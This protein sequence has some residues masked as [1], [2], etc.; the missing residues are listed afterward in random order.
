MKRFIVVLMVLLCVSSVYAYRKH[1]LIENFTATWCGYCPYVAQAITELEVQYGDSLNVVKY[2]PSSTDPFYRACSVTRSSYY[3]VPGYPTSIIAGNKAVVGGWNGVI[4]P[5]NNYVIQSF[6]E[7]TP[8]SIKVAITDFDRN[9]LTA[10]AKIKVFMTSNTSIPI[11]PSLKLRVVVVEDSIFYNWQNMD[12]LR[13]VVRDMLPNAT[14]TSISMSYGDSAEYNFSFSMTGTW[15][16]PYY[17]VVAFVQSDSIYTIR[18]YNN[19][20]TLNAGKVIQSGKARV[21]VDYGNVVALFEGI[22]D[23]NG[24]GR[25]ERNESGL[26]N[27]AFT[28]VTPFADA[29]DLNINI[30]SLDP[31]LEVLNGTFTIPLLPVGDTVSVQ[32]NLQASNFSAPHIAQLKVDYLWDGTKQKSDTFR[33]KLGVDSVLVWDGSF[34]PMV[35]NYVKPYINPLGFAYEW[36]SEADSGKPYLYDDYKHILYMAGALFPD[37]SVFS[38][39]KTAIDSG[40]NLIISGQNIAEQADSTDQEFLSDYLGIEFLVPNTADRKLKGTGIVFVETDSILFGGSGAYNNQNSKD[41]I[42]GIFNGNVIYPVLNYR[43]LTEPSDVDSLAGVYVE[44][45]SGSKVIFLAFGVEG[46]G[47][48]GN[49]MTKTNFMRRLFQG[50]TTGIGESDKLKSFQSTMVK[51][52]SILAIVSGYSGELSLYDATG[53]LVHTLRVQNGL[54]KVDNSLNPGIYFLVFKRNGD[55]FRSRVII[56]E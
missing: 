55:L 47:S 52:G 4:T 45:S 40:K 1:V 24:N 8:C 11:P 50:I 16:A 20:Y 27:I 31:D 53:R 56:V 33:F 46:V 36:Q 30:T 42:R 43:S 9:A 6:N 3:T 7:T 17:Y 49:Y 22:D 14:G 15:R 21:Q 10:N 34:D 5:L 37:T 48:T 29:H 25:L 38:W 35:A 54:L 13:Y 2:H 19:S 12:I 51:R 18:D 28:S 26:A 41:V 44:K 39:L 32:V 23:S